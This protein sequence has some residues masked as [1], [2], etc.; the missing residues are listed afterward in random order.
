[1]DAEFSEFSYGFAVTS[2]LAARLR[3]LKAAPV[4]P[5]LLAE[6]ELGWDVKLQSRAG[7]VVFVQFKISEALTTRRALEWSTYGRKYF[8]IYIRRQSYSDQH[9]LLKSLAKRERF[10]YYLAPRFYELT[11][12]DQAYTRS[13]VLANSVS[14]PLRNLPELQDDDQHYICFK[15][16]TDARWYSEEP[17]R[18]RSLPAQQ[19][20]EEIVTHIDSD[21]TPLSLSR[22]AGLRDN[23]LSA[24]GRKALAQE[25]TAQNPTYSKVVRDIQ[26]LSRT[27]LSA[28]ALFVT[29][30]SE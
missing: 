10:V 4:F 6:G 18:V 9:N 3:T 17:Q 28:E 27:F 1:M 29:K 23:L 2:E 15:N 25:M 30:A 21:K 24:V 22:L 19:L 13:R 8:R 12:F 20:P 5:S 7:A 26:Y 16:G 11:S 14:F